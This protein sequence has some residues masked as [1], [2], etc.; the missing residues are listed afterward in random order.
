MA[1]GSRLIRSEVE[2]ALRFDESIFFVTPAP[3]GFSSRQTSS[4]YADSSDASSTTSTLE[5]EAQEERSPVSTLSLPVEASPIPSPLISP[6][7]GGT[8]KGLRKVSSSNLLFLESNDEPE[9]S[10]ENK[11]ALVTLPEGPGRDESLGS[12]ASIFHDSDSVCS[13]PSFCFTTDGMPRIVTATSFQDFANQNGAAQSN[14][15]KSMHSDGFTQTSVDSP[16]LQTR[17]VGKS[18]NFDGFIQA[19]VSPMLQGR[20]IS[21]SPTIHYRSMDT[22]FSKLA[23]GGKPRLTITTD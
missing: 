22:Q 4:S 10:S 19:A 1:I 12:M 8:V 23:V 20:R 6:C 15:G 5:E 17:K 21:L 9:E 3:P 13:L 14:V 18:M 16:L 2:H 11:P 7:Y